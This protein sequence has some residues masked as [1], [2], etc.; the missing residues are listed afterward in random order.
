M[1]STNMAM[2]SWNHHEIMKQKPW[3]PPVSSVNG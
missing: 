2:K 3:N 1:L